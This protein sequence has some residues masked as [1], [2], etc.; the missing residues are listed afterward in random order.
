MPKLL[1]LIAKP[2]LLFALT[3]VL[4][5]LVPAGQGH[6]QGYKVPGSPGEIRLS[7]APV[8]KAAAP[9]VVNVYATRK[10]RQQNSLPSIFND[11]FFR[12]FF[13]APGLGAPRERVQ[14]ALGSGVI[15][16]E[17]GLIVTNNHVI[18][19]A[20][21]VR[22]VLADK[23]EFAADIVL[24]EERADLAILRIK[25]NPGNL[26]HI[27]FASSDSLEVGDLVLAIG[28]PFGVGQTVTSGIVSAVA[29][30]QANINDMGFFI[31]TDA[32]INPGN[33]GGALVDM[34][35]RLVG[36]NTAIF[37][38]SG[39]SIGI[40]FA[41]PSE[42]VQLVVAS[43]ES[44]GK[45]QRP[46]FGG[47]V[48]AVTSEIASTLGF[49]RPVG[50]IV[51]RLSPGGPAEKSGL[52]VGDV[53]VAIDGR[54]IVD[55]GSFKYRYITRGI[56]A[57]SELT[58]L[59]NGKQRKISI[60]LAAAP[61][62]RP[63]DVR[64]IRAASPFAGVKI[65]NLSPAVAE[66]IGLD[67]EENGVVIVDIARN[68]PAARAGFKPGDIVL[69]VNGVDIDSTSTLDDVASSGA[70]VWRLSVERDGRVL[71]QVFR[72]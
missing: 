44:G 52:Q 6:A 35:G 20:D 61:E 29:R 42:M 43:A 28:Y 50:V 53:I 48:Q 49:N 71:Q 19:G 18:E 46:W 12:R 41:I 7:F 47:E 26:P 60:E 55:P 69:N 40:G 9:A 62:T 33:S 15:V 57:V 2:N 68:S 27:S 59:R 3:F 1:D 51:S 65:A 5:G 58:V 56:G 10:V 25:G 31:Q 4:A 21:E 32:A 22:V 64:L 8:V 63:R 11:P 67:G 34:D 66:E 23:R 37:S 39:G 16:D 54:E 14:N 17:Q 38:R 24:K 36:I 30:T 13:D 72:G 45:V 70:H